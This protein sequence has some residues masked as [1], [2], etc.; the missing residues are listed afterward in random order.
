MLITTAQLLFYRLFY[1]RFI[2]NPIEN[3]LD[4]LMC[5]QLQSLWITPTAAV[6]S[7]VFGHWLQ[8]G[9]PLRVCAE[10]QRLLWLVPPRQGAAPAHGHRHA[11]D[12][13][14]PRE[15]PSCLG[16]ACTQRSTEHHAA[17]TVHTALCREHPRSSVESSVRGV[18]AKSTAP[19]IAAGGERADRTARAAAVDRSLEAAG[20][21]VR[22]LPQPADARQVKTVPLPC[23]S[24]AFR[25]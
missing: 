11:G 18:S 19:P 5:L 20:A 13:L 10:G 9:Q 1:Q 12:G 8:A 6:S 21:R 22:D 14:Q 4:L 3:F 23:V 15:G 17:H 24:T 16:S 2:S 25:G 7:H